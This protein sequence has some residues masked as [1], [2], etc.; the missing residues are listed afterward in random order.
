MSQIFKLFRL[1]QIDSQLD[2]LRARM[3]EVE[4]LLAQDETLR[5]AQA[6]RDEAA[7]QTQ[8]AR[9]ALRRLE[10][11]VTAQRIKIEQT[12]ATLYGGKV[13]SPKELQDMQNEAAS[14]K[15][16]LTVLED[17]QLEGMLAVEEAESAE[18]SAEER[19]ESVR[20]KLARQHAT[21]IEEQARL[22]NEAER[23]E[24]EREVTVATIPADE[25]RL[26][27]QLR[28]QR[29]GV[30]VAKVTN[31]ACA[32]CGTTLSAAL[33]HAARVSTEI[34]RCDTCGR[35]LYSG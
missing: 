1:Q 15:K 25:L 34:T 5:A 6:G 19:L 9:K 28:K 26:Y 18:K 13:R 3:Q 10:E 27:D 23:A 24:L 14:L 33:L 35:I 29:R 30:A 16:F 32:A 21:L 11:N 31:R 12:E 20:L 22:K 8:E 4:R 17:R 7:G 2:S